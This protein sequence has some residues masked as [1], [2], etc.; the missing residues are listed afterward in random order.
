MKPAFDTPNSSINVPAF[1]SD[2]VGANMDK[3]VV[4]AIVD[5]T[6]DFTNPDLAERAYTFSPELQEKLGCDAHG[7]NASAE[8]TD[9]KL[10]KVTGE[11]HGTHCAGIA[12]ASW[13]GHGISGVASN[14]RIVSIQNT[15]TRTAVGNNRTSLGNILRAYDFVKRANEEGVGIK[16]TNNSWGL[17]QS[18]KA[19]DAA[20]R[21]LGETQ[22]V[23]TIFAAGNDHRD[24]DISGVLD[25]T[26]A[27]NPYA[28]I[29]AATD[30]TDAFATFTNHGDGT[31]SLAAPGVG[32]LS[33]VF[34]DGGMY[35]PSATPDSNI[36]YE[37]FEGGDPIVTIQQI[38]AEGNPVS[39]P[40]AVGTD[41]HLNGSKGVVAPVDLAYDTGSGE[42]FGWPARTFRFDFDLAAA[43]EQTGIDVVQSL[44]EAQSLYFGVGV[45]KPGGYAETSI[46]G[47]MTSITGDAE[48]MAMGPEGTVFGPM[49]SISVSLIDGEHSLDLDGLG[50]H[51]IIDLKLETNEEYD[52]FCFDTVGLGTQMV[53]YGYKSGTSM[54]CPFVTGA[55]AVLSA[56]TDLEGAELASLVRSKVR[57]P[58]AGPLDVETGGVFDFAVEGSP[59]DGGAEA[60]APRLQFDQV[61][62]RRDELDVVPRRDLV[63]RRQRRHAGL[64]ERLG[65]RVPSQRHGQA[66]RHGRLPA[67]PGW[68]VVTRGGVT[69]GQ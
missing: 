1:G 42:L 16:V 66:R 10:Q 23:V 58:E 4:I 47:V 46:S 11:D 51:L 33:T 62:P 21:E 54:A 49:G 5:N 38:D 68:G 25:A 22:G 56:Q 26:Y 37:D 6:V 3:E 52:T 9:G 24:N 31:V 69:R 14:A 36:L 34:S 19:L 32:I 39:T 57:I 35:L 7:F 60:L 15:G 41:A 30:L 2:Q 29:V 53:P 8:S 48:F 63:A 55:A 44:K 59:D 27:D 64:G 12:G 61:L 13:D 65:T 28:V 17:Y 20:V 67:S 45:G 43:Q 50:E 40:G 18:S